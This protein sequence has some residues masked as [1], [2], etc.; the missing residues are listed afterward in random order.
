MRNKQEVKTKQKMAAKESRIDWE[1]P[2]YPENHDFEKIAIIEG[3]F[4][5]GGTVTIRGRE[6]RLIVLETPKG[7]RTVWLG[8]VL[9]SS[10]MDDYPE[11]GDQVGI[12]YLGTKK[13]TSGFSYRDFDTRV[14][15]VLKE[16]RTAE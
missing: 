3:T 6:T 16:E 13:S 1:A 7:E 9:E 2:K 12:K 8:A 4:V 15:H 14:I 11:A 5:R 10:L